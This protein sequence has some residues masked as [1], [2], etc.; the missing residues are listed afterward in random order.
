V[1]EE[2]GDNPSEV[3]NVAAQLK[4]F[5]GAMCE[6]TVWATDNL[7]KDRRLTEAPLTAEYTDPGHWWVPKEV[8]RRPQMDD[9][10]CRSCTA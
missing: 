10:P 1:S 7:S 3:V 9:P 4:D 5:N 2:E 6:E 8:G